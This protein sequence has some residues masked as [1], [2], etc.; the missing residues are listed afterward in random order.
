LVC[1]WTFSAR[2]NANRV[3]VSKNDRPSHFESCLRQANLA[4]SKTKPIF[5]AKRK[6]LYP[7]SP[8]VGGEGVNDTGWTMLAQ[9]W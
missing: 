8:A 6:L 9:D 4:F 7:F 1:L 3:V 5:D 2:L